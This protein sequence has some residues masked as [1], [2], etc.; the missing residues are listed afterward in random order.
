MD[1]WEELTKLGF[2]LDFHRTRFTMLD[3]AIESQKDWPK[4][5][6]YELMSYS[7]TLY[8]GNEIL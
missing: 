7:E 4:M 6:D 5:A 3:E 1:T 8:T 2:D